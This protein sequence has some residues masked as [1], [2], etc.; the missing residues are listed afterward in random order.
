MGYRFSDK[1]VVKLER[2]GLFVST[3]HQIMRFYTKWPLR[4][5]HCIASDLCE[6]FT[7]L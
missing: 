6:A 4:G 1:G 5:I 3:F 2:Q 7:M